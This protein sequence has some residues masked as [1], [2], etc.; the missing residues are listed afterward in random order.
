MEK[1]TDEIILRNSSN[2]NFSKQQENIPALFLDRDG[3]LVREVH[4]LNSVEDVAL[5]IGSIQLL[6][7]AYLAK[8]PVVIVTNQSGISRGILSWDDYK[9]ITQTIIKLI[10]EPSPVSAI[11]SNS[12]GPD[13]QENSWRKPSPLM[14]QIAASKLS[15]DLSRSILIGDRLSDLQA[16]VRAGLSCVM[17]VL[18]GHGE[19]ERQEILSHLDTRGRFISGVHKSDFLKLNTLHDFPFEKLLK[20]N[21]STESYP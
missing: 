15:I 2:L 11:Y 7:T 4:Y 19:E 10:G 12:L 3:V 14:L 18:T 21:Y 13:A 9:S 17:H 5:E 1:Y 6:R 20:R 8:W 16:G